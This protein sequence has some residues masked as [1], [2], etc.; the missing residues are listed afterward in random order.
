MSTSKTS[1]TLFFILQNLHFIV[2]R[3]IRGGKMTMIV[4]IDNPMEHKKK[5]RNDKE[6]IRKVDNNMTKIMALVA[7][8]SIAV[9]LMVISMIV[10]TSGA[11]VTTAVNYV[12]SE[13][14]KAEAAPVVEYNNEVDTLL[15]EVIF[16]DNKVSG[17]TEEDILDFI[18]EETATEETAA[19]TEI[20]P[21]R[22]EKPAVT[23]KESQTVVPSKTEPTVKAEKT[24]T[25][26][27]QTTAADKSKTPVVE[28]KKV[29]TDTKVTDTKATTENKTQTTQP[30]QNTTTSTTTETTEANFWCVFCGAGSATYKAAEDHFAN[31]HYTSGVLREPPVRDTT[32]IDPS[33]II[34]DGMES[35]DVCNTC[36]Q[37]FVNAHESYNNHTNNAHR[38]SKEEL[39]AL[40]DEEE[41]K[42]AELQKLLLGEQNQQNQQ[43]VDTQRQTDDTTQQTVEEPAAQSEAPTE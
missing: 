23:A 12:K 38:M 39:K 42:S 32:P 20:A 41:R 9:K 40:R 16:S 6:K 29:V 22:D 5:K 36:G 30:V 33:T 7:S 27:S 1:H 3:F 35:Y 18:A 19:S 25:A 10:G 17:V 2:D 13:S 34:K 37:A 15:E 21:V 4:I 8:K 14:V 31:V 26:K 43:T 24:E 28:D 11:A